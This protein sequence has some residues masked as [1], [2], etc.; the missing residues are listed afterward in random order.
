MI[1]KVLFW[2][3]SSV[4][5]KPFAKPVV[6]IIITCNYGDTKSSLSIFHIINGLQCLKILV[7]TTD[8]SVKK[9]RK[10]KKKKDNSVTKS[11]RKFVIQL[12]LVEE[13]Q[14]Y[15]V[16]LCIL[17][18]DALV[19]VMCFDL[20]WMTQRTSLSKCCLFFLLL[21]TIK[22]GYFRPEWPPFTTKKM[23][24]RTWKGPFLQ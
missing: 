11:D 19:R 24:F 23:N 10:K 8:N 22:H 1:F 14:M 12:K 15:I 9:K 13:A 3:T 7:L 4:W 6:S 2:I 5:T 16:S 17:P 20:C 21:F 18:C